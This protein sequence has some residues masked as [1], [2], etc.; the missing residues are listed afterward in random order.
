MR[1]IF[2]FVIIFVVYC[3]LLQVQVLTRHG[4]RTPIYI[5]PNYFSK[6][7]CTSGCEGILT[8][9]GKRQ[10]YLLGNNFRS[11]YYNYL[12]NISPLDVKVYSTNYNR[13]KESALLFLSGLFQSHYHTFEIELNGNIHPNYRKIHSLAEKVHQ[14]KNWIDFHKKHEKLFKD[15]LQKFNL[16]EFSWLQFF[17]IHHCHTTH[18][19]SFPSSF[20]LTK[21]IKSIVE[22]EWNSYASNEKYIK[23]GIG[24]FV[25][26]IY[27][28]F[29][30][31][32]P[33]ILYSGHDTSIA[34]IL[35]YFKVYDGIFP[36]YSS[37]IIF[38]LHEKKKKFFKIFYNFKFLKKIYL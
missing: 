34:P 7:N 13:T 10:Q 27:K 23:V 20:E 1:S 17:D 30:L 24:K 15:L 29:S 25:K 26:M 31:K 12:S 22:F 38:E 19:I 35:A 14:T 11:R 3:K 21:F 28:N 36:E 9:R 33:F 32:T 6:W 2:I 4:D 8:E 5:F 37:H 18:N 16:T